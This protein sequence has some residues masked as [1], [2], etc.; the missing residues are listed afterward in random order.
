MNPP[1]HGGCSACLDSEDG[2]VCRS[3][4]AKC[5]APVLDGPAGEVTRLLA[6]LGPVL[7]FEPGHPGDGGVLGLRVLPGE[8][9]LQLAFSPGC[10]GGSELADRAFQT[11]R[12][13]LPDTDIYVLP[14]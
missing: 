3:G 1:V 7:G 14:A 12:G 10:G 13:L 5:A 8:V 6:A 9:E 11:L 4:P 2:P